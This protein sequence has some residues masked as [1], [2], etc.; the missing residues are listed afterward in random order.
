MTRLRYVDVLTLP[1]VGQAAPSTLPYQAVIFDLFG[2]LTRAV[3]RSAWHARIA[4]TLGCD[5]VAFGL[6]LDQ[7][8]AARARGGDPRMELR[9]LAW[10]LGRRP[11][12]AQVSEA[13]R[14]R[15][16][17]ILASIRLRPD[18]VST[19]WTL[20]GS[21]LRIGLVSDCTAELPRLVTRT[22]IGALLDAA[23]Y[24]SQLGVVKPHP[25]LFLTA[26]HRLGVSPAHCL[27]V[28]DGGGQELSGARAVGMTAV[29]LVAPD[30]SRHLTFAAE[31][32]W[33]GPVITSL[34][35]VLNLAL[36]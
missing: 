7:T 30:L 22:P 29:R 18:A 23:V 25:S 19:L 32:N 24:S 27:Y 2:T 13:L 5:P 31:A 14:M 11:S 26:S 8:F 3:R 10:R 17:A 36:P 1:A 21:G 12:P 16:A 28:G 33:T 9:R 4:R 34:A 15:S 20:R 35:E 6:L